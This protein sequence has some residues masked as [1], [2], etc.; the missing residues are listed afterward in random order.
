MQV[1]SPNR[2]PGP[3]SATGF[4]Y[5]RS[6]DASIGIVRS[7]ASSSRLSSSR[8]TSTLVSRLKNPCAPPCVF[9]C[10]IGV[11]IA[12]CAIPSTM[13]N[14]V[15]PNSPS[16]QITSP[17]RYRRFTIA[18][19]FNSRNVPDTPAN[20]GSRCSSSAVSVCVSALA[21]IAVPATPLFVSAPVGQDTMH[22]P[23][24]MHVESP[25]GVF[26]SNAIPAE[27]PLP[28][29]PSTKLFLISSHPRMHRSHKIHAS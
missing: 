18:P 6:T 25:I 12:T 19:R 28:I 16:R 1:I 23:H 11:E 27:Y 9:T 20:T 15:D 22:S 24:E 17:L 29:R 10:A 7:R 2:S 14:A 21:A 8:P 26:K 13:K 5:A 3:S 4:P